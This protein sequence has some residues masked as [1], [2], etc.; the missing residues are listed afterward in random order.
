MSSFSTSWLRRI[1]SGLHSRAGN[2]TPARLSTPAPEG[3][4]EDCS[5]CAQSAHHG[6]DCE[7][8]GL[9]STDD[10][11]AA[12]RSAKEIGAAR[13]CTVTSGGALSDNE[14]DA[15]LDC[16]ERVRSEVDIALDASLGF[17]DEQRALRLGAAGVTR[18]NHNLETSPDYYPTICT[19]H[20]F[21]QRVA[22]VETVISKGFSA[23]SGGIIG[24][25]E[26]PA[27]RL[28]LAF[29]LAKLGVDCVPINILNPRPGTPLGTPNLWNRWRL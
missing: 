1:G 10:I 24:M 26:T 14:F 13:F 12:A 23:C 7:T 28:D 19:T 18:Y 17:L 25:G 29:S 20:T 15:L 5:F 27:Q 2:S 11:L 6:A 8:Y 16:L 22:T 4:G 21:D 9:R 3:A